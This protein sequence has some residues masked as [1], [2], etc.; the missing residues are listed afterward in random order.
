MV[1]G[2][3]AG[4]GLAAAFKPVGYGW[5]AV[6][7]L[8]VLFW[9][10]RDSGVRRRLLIGAIFG[11]AFMGVHIWWMQPS[12]GVAAWAALVTTQTIWLTGACVLIGSLTRFRWWPLWAATAWLSVEDLRASVPFGGF[13]WGRL[14]YASVDTPW[15]GL[16]PYL[17][18]AGS[19]FMVALLAASFSTLFP[20]PQKGP[21]T[22]QRT[23]AGRELWPGTLAPPASVVAA[24]STRSRPDDA[25]SSLLVRCLLAVVVLAATLLPLLAPYHTPAVGSAT[26]AV[27]QGGVPG[28]GNDVAGNYRQVTASHVA[29]SQRLGAQ[30]RS[31]LV[32]SPDFVIWPESSVSVDPRADPTLEIGIR[33]A[34]A[35]LDRPLLVGQITANDDGRTVLNQGVVRTNTAPTTGR[36]TYSKRHPVPFGE[37]I[38]FRSVL[39]GLSP[40]LRQIPRDMLEGGVP[41]PLILNGVR[42]ADAICFDVAYSD[43]IAPQVRQGASLVVVQTSN[44][45]FIGSSQLAQQFAISRAQALITGRTVVVSSLNGLTGAISA[46]GAVIKSLPVRTPA[47]MVVSV[48]LRAGLTPAVRWERWIALAATGS[49]A[50]GLATIAAVAISRRRMRP[51][52]AGTA[53]TPPTA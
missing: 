9:S 31:G 52:H 25:A 30:V 8:T 38:P 28:A 18:T 5:L 20:A 2:S 44:A 35:A 46:D 43:V 17:G 26:V 39:Q 41:T 12:R 45:A 32:P 10:L 23:A 27:V 40:Q 53:T 11:W 24:L 13:P 51:R 33:D 15:Q 22:Q 14:A 36:Q 6:L 34:M 7:S 21:R 42:V 37:Y 19:G 4:L 16:L 48:P 3:L 29:L 50:T 49:T 47:L 1:V